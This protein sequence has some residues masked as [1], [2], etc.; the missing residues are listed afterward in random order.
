M[1]EY[2][3][4]KVL[5]ATTQCVTMLLI[6]LLLEAT[7][8][9][10]DSQSANGGRPNASVLPEQLMRLDVTHI[11][12]AMHSAPAP[13]KFIGSTTS[14]TG[15]GV[16]V[17]ECTE[18]RHRHGYVLH[19]TTHQP[20]LLCAGPSVKVHE[21]PPQPATAKPAP[22]PA[23][24]TPRATPEAATPTPIPAWLKRLNHRH[25]DPHRHWLPARYRYIGDGTSRRAQPVAL[26]ECVG[27]GHVI[28]MAVDR[29]TGG[30]IVLFERDHAD[31][32]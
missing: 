11:D 19:W 28:A 30:P 4:S 26:Y 16:A 27:C 12:R 23:P 1:P 17:Y 13:M 14:R 22:G 20:H 6:T 10:P 24:E 29:F 5:S 2:L 3:P 31:P 15:Q 21:P 9:F 32:R 25:W 18:C 7:M 8:M